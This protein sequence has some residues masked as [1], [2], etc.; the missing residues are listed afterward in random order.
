MLGR[1]VPPEISNGIKQGFSAPDGSWFMGE[2]IKF[3]ADRL[4]KL[5]AAIYECLDKT[6]VSDLIIGHLEGRQNRL[7]FDPVPAHR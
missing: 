2:S 6:A 5:D 3:V 7:A 1:Y 4:I